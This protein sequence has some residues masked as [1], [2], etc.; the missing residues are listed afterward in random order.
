[1]Y[2]REDSNLHTP[3]TPLMT[4]YKTGALREYLTVNMPVFHKPFGP[5]QQLGLTVKFSIKLT[6][7]FPW[8][9]ITV[10]IPFD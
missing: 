8:N 9:V 10:G 3:L 6:D 2:S 4:V 7:V 5:K 1:M